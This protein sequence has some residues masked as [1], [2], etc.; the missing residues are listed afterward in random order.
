[1]IH[2]YQKKK[3]TM[4][5]DEYKNLTNMLVLHMR[6]EENR[7]EDGDDN[8]GIRKSELIAWYLDQ[9]QDQID[10]EAELLER[11]ALVEKII[12]RLMYHDQ[13]IIPLTTGAL[14]GQDNVD[15]EEKEEEDP[16]LVVHPN[17]VIDI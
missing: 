8:Q 17:Y 4:S 9:I 1:M 7:I 16:L 13:I 10:D 2:K 12:T 14:D 15:D 5:F 3:L 11:K 6:S